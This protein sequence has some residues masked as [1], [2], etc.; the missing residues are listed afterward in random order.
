MLQCCEREEDEDDKDDFEAHAQSGTDDIETKGNMCHHEVW[1]Q[2]EMHWW[3]QGC[4]LCV[5]SGFPYTEGT[6]HTTDGGSDIEEEDAT[7]CWCER[8]YA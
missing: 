2:Y 3:P 4:P 1:D 7:V 6:P 5:S 8:M